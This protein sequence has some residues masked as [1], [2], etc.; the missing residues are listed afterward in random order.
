MLYLKLSVS[1]HFLRYFLSS[2]LLSDPKAPIHPLRFRSVVIFF[3][4]VYLTSQNELGTPSSVLVAPCVYISPFYTPGLHL[5][6]LISKFI[7]RYFYPVPV[8]FLK[9]PM[10]PLLTNLF[11]LHFIFQLH[12]HS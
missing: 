5:F 7:S 9:S 4:K 11:H 1:L 6:H 10:T 3:G 8:L 2:F 12:K